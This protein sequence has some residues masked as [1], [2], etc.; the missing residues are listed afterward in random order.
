LIRLT[1]LQLVVCDAGTDT[2]RSTTASVLLQWWFNF[3]VKMFTFI[4]SYIN[5][6][7]VPWRIAILID[8]SPCG[9]AA[10]KRAEGVV[11]G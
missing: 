7:P 11:R 6:L 9:R 4:F 8:A 10:A 3:C 5:L 2:S 1:S